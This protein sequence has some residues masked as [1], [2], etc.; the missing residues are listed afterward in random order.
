MK[1]KIRYRPL[2]RLGRTGW[3]RMGAD[4][5]DRLIAA[6]VNAGGS[7]MTAGGGGKDGFAQRVFDRDGAKS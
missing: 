3:E 1:Y 7:R 6:A 4:E 5:Q 2:E